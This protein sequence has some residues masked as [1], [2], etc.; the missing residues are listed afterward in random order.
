MMQMRNTVQRELVYR[1]VQ[2]NR[3]HPTADDI[4]SIIHE[5]YPKVSRATVYRNLSVLAQMGKIKQIQI[6][7]GADRYD[8]ECKPHY[9]FC[10]QK[11][12][13]IFDMDIPIFPEIEEKIGSS[14][15]FE[16]TGYKLVFTGLC[17][18]CK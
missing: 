6:P 2:K 7:A 16:I 15:D 3:T 10:C 8:F 18:E 5:E 11:C 4:F 14:S 17:S 9:H 12:G 13:K 1:A